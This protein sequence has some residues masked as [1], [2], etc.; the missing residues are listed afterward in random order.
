[1]H[2]GTVACAKKRTVWERMSVWTCRGM[3]FSDGKEDEKNLK[4]E[5]AKVRVHEEVTNNE[6]I[7]YWM[8]C[9]QG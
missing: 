5:R 6:K 8:G 9:P 2:R 4:V 1:M 7:G 3:R